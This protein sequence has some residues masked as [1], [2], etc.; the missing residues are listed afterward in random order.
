MHHAAG[1]F[2][3][4]SDDG[5][6]DERPP[7]RVEV[8]AFCLDRTEVNVARYAS[9]GHCKPARA[10]RAD[11][12]NAGYEDRR[13]HP[14]NCVDHGQ[15]T[16]F[17]A[18]AG[19]RLPREI[20]WERAARGDDG[21]RYPWGQ[22]PPDETRVNVCG[23]E[24]ARVHR[25]WPPMHQGDDGFAKT[26]P[27]GMFAAGA[28]ALGVLDMAGNVWEWTAD[29]HAPYPGAPKGDATLWAELA[30]R[31]IV[32]GGGWLHNAAVRLRSANRHSYAANESNGHLGF[33]CAYQPHD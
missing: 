3:I 19:G 33:R 30:K 28:T 31:R 11:N 26:A 15:A 17:C 2:V 32:R 24:C 25:G 4:G 20:E 1:T 14:I 8:A 5:E 22:A 12:C 21:R 16:A 7:H 13:E 6:S 9:C 23:R 10:V 27:V 18:H 29:A